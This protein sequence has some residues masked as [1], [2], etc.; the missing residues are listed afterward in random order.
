MKLIALLL[1]I[2]NISYSYGKDIVNPKPNDDLVIK[3][4]NTSE[5]TIPADG[6][7][8]IMRAKGSKSTA[9]FA[10]G[11]GSTDSSDS[12]PTIDSGETVH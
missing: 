12:S 6:T 5:P 7:Q 10:N 2:F 9:I 4:N 3:I 11:V 1:L 8:E